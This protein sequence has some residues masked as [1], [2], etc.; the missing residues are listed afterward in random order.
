MI[1]KVRALAEQTQHG[2]AHVNRWR[3]VLVAFGVHDGVGVSGGAMTAAEAQ[4]M[5]DRHSSPVWDLVVAELVALEAAPPAVKPEVSVTA[6]GGVTEGEDAVFTLTA[7]PAPASALS[8]SVTVSAAGDFGAATGGRTV[9]IPTSGSATLTLPTTDDTTDE[10]DGSV[11]LTV[12]A[13]SDYTVGAL[14]SETVSVTDNDETPVGYTVDAAVVAKVQNLAAQTQHGS[15]HVNRWNRVLVAFGVHDGVGVSGGAMTAAEAQQMADRHSSPVWDEVVAEL[16]ALE[17]APQQ[18]PPPPPPPTPVVNITSAVGGTEG[19]PMTFTVTASPAPTTDLPVTVTISV[20]GDYGV[21]AG[22]RTVTIPTSGTATLTV[23]TTDDNADETDGSVTATVNAGSDYTVSATQGTATVTVSDDDDPPVVVPVVTITSGS[24]V[25]EGADAT[26]TLSANP[27]PTA[28]LD[29]VVTITAAGDY[30]V[31]AG[32]RTVTIPTTG[33]ATLT[34]AT[35]GD[36]TDETDGSVTATVVDGADYDPGVS[37]TATVSVADDDPPPAQDEP[38]Q[39][40][41]LADCG[42]DEP[43]MTINNPEASRSDPT[44]DFQV[45]LDCKPAA[46]LT[47]LLIPVRD[48]TV[49]N[50]ILIV[51]T[52][53][54]TTATVTIPIGT[55]HQLSLAIGWAP[56]VANRNAQG[57]VTYTDAAEDPA[58]PVVYLTFDDGPHPVHTAEVLDVLRRY[59]ARATFFVVGTMVERFPHLLNRILLEGHTVANHTWNHENLTKLSGEAIDLTLERTQE[60]LG[61]NATACMR[62]PYGAINDLVRQR[63]EEHGLEVIMWSASANDWLDLTPDMIA[64]RIVAGAVDGGIIL[65][66]DGGGDRSRTVQGLDLA[67]QHM[68]NQGIRFKPICA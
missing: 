14:S 18:T 22:Q 65:M 23:D 60:L 24:A 15:V 44:V 28:D 58:G 12:N 19:D 1:T 7:N 41:V 40:A 42:P 2:S 11:T 64:E 68:S 25:T 8:V 47:V 45:S 62:P 54:Q 56:G 39:P 59:G 21:T 16:T 33:T 34:I 57:T 49:G 48:G 4:Q 38:D 30:G 55:E 27:A 3:R 36:Q 52:S 26:F 43:T 29:V 61:A 31:T 10:P 20:S 13:G 63:A 46:S 53:Q 35:T 67:L 50:N 9:T 66:H 51:F 17:A 32:S 5:A 6:S 37:K